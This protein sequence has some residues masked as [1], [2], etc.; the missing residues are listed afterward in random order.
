MDCAFAGHLMETIESENLLHR[1]FGFLTFIADKAVVVGISNFLR[2]IYF[3][4]Q[5]RP[6]T[7]AMFSLLRTNTCR[8]HPLYWESELIGENALGARNAAQRKLLDELGIPAENVPV[9][10]FIPL[11]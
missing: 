10:E 5:Q 4:D 11:G 9:D 2:L 8:S 3:L 1:G 6:A 7:K